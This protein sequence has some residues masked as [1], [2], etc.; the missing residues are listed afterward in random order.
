MFLLV[1]PIDDEAPKGRLITPQVQSIRAILDK[2]A[3]A[4]I[5]QTNEISHTLD[6]LKTAAGFS[7]LRFTMS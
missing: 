4:I 1:I 7:N 2:N 5:A 3:I 6:S